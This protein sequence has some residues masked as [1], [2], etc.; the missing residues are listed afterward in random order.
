M[1]YV[2]L[3]ARASLRTPSNNARVIC[4]S[5]SPEHRSVTDEASQPTDKTAGWQQA[6]TLRLPASARDNARRLA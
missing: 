1:G 2:V 5:R 4:T 3:R 6:R